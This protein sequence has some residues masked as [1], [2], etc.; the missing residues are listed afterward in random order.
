MEKIV[1]D[2]DGNKSRRIWMPGPKPKGYVKFLVNVPSEYME[3]MKWNNELCG[4]NNPVSE[5]IRQ[6]IRGS[7]C[8]L[9]YANLVKQ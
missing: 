7:L 2:V 4:G 1:V 8:G 3:I 5:Q 9:V 6:A